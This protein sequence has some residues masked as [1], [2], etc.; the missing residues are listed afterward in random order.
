MSV[1]FSVVVSI[2]AI[3]NVAALPDPN[4]LDACGVTVS[5]RIVGGEVTGID[6][7]PWTALL[8]YKKGDAKVFACGGS[9][10]DNQHVIT[11]A[12]CTVEKEATLTGVRLGEWNISSPMD[13]FEADDC[14]DDPIDIPIARVFK[15]PEYNVKG[16][17]ENDIAILRLTKPVTYSYFVKPICLPLDKE[18]QAKTNFSDAKFVVAGWGRT[19][20]KQQSDVKMKV[21]LDWVNLNACNEVYNKSKIQIS[22]RQ[23]CAGGKMAKDSCQGDSG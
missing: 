9:L 5:D 19:E 14:T 10:I 7:F 13:C 16:E 21:I 18:L 17:E 8:E 22:M 3:I 4:V 1:L 15:H 2:F 23:L 12:H 6:E 11:A 20:K